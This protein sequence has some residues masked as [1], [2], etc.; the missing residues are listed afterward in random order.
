MTNPASQSHLRSRKHQPHITVGVGRSSL[1]NPVGSSQG[2]IDLTDSG[3]IGRSRSRIDNSPHELLHNRSSCWTVNLNRIGLMLV[4][5]LAISVCDFFNHVFFLV[6]SIISQ[7]L[8]T[9][10]MLSYRYFNSPAH[11]ETLNAVV[12]DVIA[13]FFH[14][15]TDIDP[16][17]A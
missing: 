6:G 4:N 14:I 13:H 7:G 1:T 17:F 5:H 2:S 11:W 12:I 8:E 15:A 3:F 10:G 16:F 9:I